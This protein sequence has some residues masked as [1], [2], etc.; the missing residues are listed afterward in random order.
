MNAV[1]SDIL[2]VLSST[3][4]PKTIHLGAQP[5]HSMLISQG[6][7][8]N[9]VVQQTWEIIRA[10]NNLFQQTWK[11]ILAGNNLFQQTWKVIQC[12]TCDL[13]SAFRQGCQITNFTKF[14]KFEKAGKY[15][16]AQV[17]SCG[18]AS[19]C[20]QLPAMA[21]WGERLKTSGP[22]LFL[23]EYFAGPGWKERPGFPLF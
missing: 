12:R 7:V 22:I 18:L 5:H 23:R 1:G 3:T 14:T 20:H 8:G 4:T 21:F 19:A 11:V 13:A 15:S 6:L 16:D 10:G 9:N 2:G 17:R